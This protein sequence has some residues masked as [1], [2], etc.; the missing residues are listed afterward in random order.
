ME[1][2]RWWLLLL[3][4][5]VLLNMVGPCK[6][7][8]SPQYDVCLQNQTSRLDYICLDARL[9]HDHGELIYVWLLGKYRKMNKATPGATI[10]ASLKQ[11]GKGLFRMDCISFLFTA[12]W[13]MD[14]GANLNYSRI[15]VTVP[16]VTSIVPGAGPFRSSAYVVRFYLPVKFQ[17]DPPVPVDVWNSHCVAVRKFSGYAKDE[18]TAIEAKRLTDSLSRSPWPT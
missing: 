9:F 13:D 8:K 14:F 4:N 3:P 5:I 11:N 12:S 2:P 1:K 17:A 18:N 6:A 10:S 15:A 16:I 7:I